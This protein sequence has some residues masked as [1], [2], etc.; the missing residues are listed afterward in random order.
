MYKKFNKIFQIKD[1]VS[2]ESFILQEHSKEKIEEPPQKK[3]KAS[4]GFMSVLPKKENAEAPVYR[5][6]TSITNSSPI[7]ISKM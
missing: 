1:Q 4:T 7:K 2:Q 6:E 5:K 3:F